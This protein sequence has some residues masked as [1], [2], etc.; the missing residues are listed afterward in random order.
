MHPADRKR[1]LL[2]DLTQLYATTPSTQLLSG[3]ELLL[4]AV[5]GALAETETGLRIV[6]GSG[7]R[8]VLRHTGFPL[9]A[10]DNEIAQQLGRLLVAEIQLESEEYQDQ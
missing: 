9:P 2:E 5:G 3:T 1:K 7:L 6:S 8:D 4:R 10:R